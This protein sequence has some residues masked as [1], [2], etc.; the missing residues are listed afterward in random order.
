MCSSRGYNVNSFFLLCKMNFPAFVHDFCK[1]LYKMAD[2]NR[3]MDCSHFP[4]SPI[5][6]CIYV[7]Y[8][9]YLYICIYSAHNPDRIYQFFYLPRENT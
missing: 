6:V 7:G 3:H 8:I 2:F 5:N 1:I 4:F 9:L